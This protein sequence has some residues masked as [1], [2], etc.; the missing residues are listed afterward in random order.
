[1]TAGSRTVEL[2]PIPLPERRNFMAFL[3]IAAILGAVI[4]LYV[5]D[6]V[7]KAC[8]RVRRYRAMSD[9]LDAAA[10]R[11]EVQQVRRKR[12]EA[13]GAALTSVIPAINRPPLTL[14]GVTNQPQ[15]T[16]PGSEADPTSTAQATSEAA[17][18]REATAGG[19]APAG[20]DAKPGRDAKPAREARHSH[21]AGTGPR[22][23]QP[24]RPAAAH[25]RQRPAERSG[26]A[27]HVTGPQHR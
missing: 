16:D 20:H 27:A 22:E 18:S 25:P 14:P 5:T 26:R 15:D 2:T 6:R 13:A 23:H 4:L 10:A 11:T 24:G 8:A 3:L 12:S 1:M 21:D 9:R 7:I 17:A 19:Q